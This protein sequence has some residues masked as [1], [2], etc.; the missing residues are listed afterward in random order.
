MQFADTKF[1]LIQGA[2]EIPAAGF[3]T[4]F[5]DPSVTV[6]ATKGA[7]EA[8]FR[9][10]DGAERY[11]NEDIKIKMRLNPVVETGVPGFFR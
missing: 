8:G 5:K 1:P 6:E 9:H 4:S 2:G 11:R 10:I 7:L 3:G